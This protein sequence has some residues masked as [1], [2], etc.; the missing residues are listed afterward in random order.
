MFDTHCHLY[1]D[2]LYS[3]LDKIILRTKE[4]GVNYLVIPGIDYKSSL[5]AIE[6]SNCYEN[7]Y[8]AV[9]IH[10]TTLISAENIEKEIFKIEE[11]VLKDKVVAVGEI[12]LDYYHKVNSEST[13]KVLLEK[14]LKLAIKYNKAVIIHSRHSSEDIISLIKKSGPKNFNSN[15]VF[16]CSEPEDEI[17]KIAIKYKYFIGIDG[18]ITFDKNKQDFIKKV[19]ME[20]LVLETDSPLLA[21]TKDGRK[22]RNKINYPYYL[23]EIA[24]KVSKIKNI[25]VNEIIKKT[26]SNALLL[27][28]VSSGYNETC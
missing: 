1:L 19:P 8:A 9:G 16:H 20:N 22:D 12:G 23:P 7:T 26:T 17:L 10:P 3:N 28:G 6:I 27:F 24:N 11:L 2:P 21:P 18:D 15:L 14:Q 4:V 13:Q 5:K 25:E